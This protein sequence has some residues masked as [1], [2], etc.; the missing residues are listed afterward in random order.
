MTSTPTASDAPF[1]AADVGGTHARLAL[2]RFNAEGAVAILHYS[3][4]ICAEYPDLATIL[5]TFIDTHGDAR[6]TSAAIAIAGLQVGDS[7][8]NPN[9][10]WHVSLSQTRQAAH[11]KDLA[12]INDF[13]ALAHAVPHIDLAPAELLSGQPVDP[14]KVTT[15]VVGPG[16]GLGQAARI[17][18]RPHPVVITSEAGHAALAPGNELELDILRELFKRWSHIDRERAVSGPGLL[19]LY[20]C[21]CTLHG[22]HPMLRTPADVTAAAL[23]HANPQAVTTLSVFCGLLGSL[24][25]DLV[26]AYNARAVFLAGGIPSRIRS[27]LPTSNFVARYHNKG[28]LG[29]VIKHVPIWL[30]EHGQLGLIGAAAWYQDHRSS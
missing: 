15:L 12:L 6:I 17:P 7:L 14:S 21:I 8:I 29:D 5:R 4:Y 11:L 3:E 19:N 30:I 28:A 9:L 23:A 16:T 26:L 13:E 24:I 27:F 25:G 2:V 22:V 20:E 10:P 1:I 18:H